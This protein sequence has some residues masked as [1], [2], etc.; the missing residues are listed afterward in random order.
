M[1]I[2]N[3]QICKVEK[4]NNRKSYVKELKEINTALESLVYRKNLLREFLR[5]REDGMV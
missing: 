5:G 1:P 4:M 3:P 2:P